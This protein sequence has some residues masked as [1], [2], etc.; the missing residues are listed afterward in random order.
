MQN[1]PFENPCT[2]ISTYCHCCIYRKRTAKEQ[3]LLKIRKLISNDYR[4]CINK[5]DMNISGC[6]FVTWCTCALKCHFVFSTCCQ[7]CFV[8]SRN[9]MKKKKNCTYSERMKNKC[10]VFFSHKI[11][12]NGNYDALRW[13]Y[14]FANAFV[15][16]NFFSPSWSYCFCLEI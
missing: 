8:Q 6:S 4:K 9:V 1:V 13:T 5:I 14:L 3:K 2:I 16:L 11:T 12:N 7:F 15:R 10:V